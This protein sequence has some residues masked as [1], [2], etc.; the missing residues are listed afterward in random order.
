MRNR[1][2]EKYQY[3]SIKILEKKK[4]QVE[5]VKTKMAER[6]VTQPVKDVSISTQM[7]RD[8]PITTLM[9]CEVYPDAQLIMR[10]FNSFII[11]TLMD[12]STTWG[13]Q[14]T[15]YFVGS[16]F[17][18]SSFPD[19]PPLISPAS[20]TFRIIYSEAV[21]WFPRLPGLHHHQQHLL[22]GSRCEEGARGGGTRGGERG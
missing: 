9:L 5:I 10:V 7:D 22:P 2:A 12:V 17:T 18:T 4:S 19:V 14:I 21:Q 3:K 15:R 11:S 1:E 16:Y 6:H 8:F 20:S 13:A